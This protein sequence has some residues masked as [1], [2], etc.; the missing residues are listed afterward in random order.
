[1]KKLLL[2]LLLI[3]PV[4]MADIQC[5]GEI[6]KILQY[7]NGTITVLTSY[8]DDYITMCNVKN[9]WKGVS[10]QACKGMLS[11]LL[12]AQSTGKEIVTYYRGNQYTCQNLPNYGRAPGPIYVGI[13]K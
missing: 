10:P 2:A 6:K 9:D 8:R 4:A 11:I 5:S 13:T 7:L 3:S 12:T 1:M